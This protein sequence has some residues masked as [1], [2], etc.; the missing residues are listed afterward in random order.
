MCNVPVPTFTARN[1]MTVTTT[2]GAQI[3]QKVFLPLLLEK[4]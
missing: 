3:P 1:Q 4:K 2:Q